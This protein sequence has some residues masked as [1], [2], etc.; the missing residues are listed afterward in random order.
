MLMRAQIG[1]LQQ[2]CAG[3]AAK[4]AGA[5]AKAVVRPAPRAADLA[6]LT[7][8]R[9][10][11]IEPHDPDRKRKALRIYLES[12]IFSQWGEG[13]LGDPQLGGMLEFIEAQLRADA[14]LARACE[15]A[16]DLLLP[17]AVQ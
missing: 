11:R 17:P 10:L 6:E 13:M 9:L 16:V 5:P 7:A 3:H 4:R 12:V 15:E 1:L 14:H 2:R 8:Q